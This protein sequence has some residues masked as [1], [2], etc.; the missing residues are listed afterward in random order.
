MSDQT[1]HAA[2]CIQ[3]GPLAKFGPSTF[4]GLKGIKPRFIDSK[5]GWK[6][7]EIYDS[8]LIVKTQERLL[9]SELFSSVYI[10]H[11]EALDERGELPIKLRFSEAKHQ[12]ISI[13]GFY[14]T[15]DGPGFAFAWAH[16]NIGGMG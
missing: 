7:G 8:D 9:K 3:E 4:F 15:V 10:S 13:G 2:A 12:R 11:G 6:E 14:G 16:R 1:V 5:I